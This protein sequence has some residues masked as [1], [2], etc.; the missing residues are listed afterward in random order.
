MK[1]IILL[2]ALIFVTGC[3]S[4]SQNAPPVGGDPW[5]WPTYK[6]YVKGLVCPS[7]A[8]GLKKGL[9]KL[10]FVENIHINY[11]TGMTLIYEKQPRDKG[12]EALDKMRI[13]KAIENSGY[14]VDRFVK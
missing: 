10:S 12:G 4:T 14:N 5:F 2:I 1:N 13:T 3:P 9:M 11:K 6:V 7:C 8:V